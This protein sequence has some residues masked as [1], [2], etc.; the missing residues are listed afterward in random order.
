MRSVQGFGRHKLLIFRI[1][2][3]LSFAG[4]ISRF[5]YVQLIESERYTR[6]SEK[7]RI[8]PITLEPPRGIIRDRY[9]EILVDNLP[10]YS[11]FAIPREL[12]RRDTVFAALASIINRQPASLEKIFRRDRRGPFQR[13]KIARHIGFQALAHIEENKLELPGIVYGVDPRRYYPAGVRAPHLFGYLG[14]IDEKKL[15]Q[16]REHGYER[17]DVIGKTGIEYIYESVLRGKKGFR[18]VE[19]DALGREIKVLSGLGEKPAVPGKELHLAIDAELQRHLE[20]IMEDKRGGAVLINTDNGEIIALASKP[21]YDPEIFTK[22][23][24]SKVWNA[25][26]DN[27]D[28]PLYDRMV[29]SHV[30]PGST[31]KLVLA[32]AALEEG[33]IDGTETVYCPGAYRLGRRVFKCWKKGGH[34]TVNLLQAIEG[35]CNVYFYRLIQKVGLENWVKYSRKFNFGKTTGSDLYSEFPGLVPDAAYFDRK[36]G[37]GKWSKGLLLNLSVGQGDLLVTPLQMATFAMY[38]ANRGLGFR[39]H[40]RKRIV[41]PITGDEEYFNPDTVRIE[42]ISERTWDIIHKGMF[43]VVNAPG[44]T[45]KSANPGR[46]HVAGKTGTA[47]NPHGEDHA[48]FI[49]FVPYEQ[50]QIAFCVF[51]ENGG[52]GGG[53]AAPIIRSVLRLLLRQ[54]KILIPQTVVAEE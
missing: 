35:S 11:V 15:A 51:V 14:E 13:V 45:A 19:V 39:P 24:S 33:I 48:W 40:V 54:N 3:L 4:L 34:G 9:R 6:E 8:R 44:G 20:R 38:I 7:N 46:V 52:S 18:F 32:I 28:K 1:L 12:T 41:D 50:P 21:D 53:V 25:L 17:G 30:E 36:Y 23:I 29:R 47:Q 37:K 43:N 49:G 16:M 27:P 2:L 26:R 5:A 42:G 31:Y 10:A 22:P